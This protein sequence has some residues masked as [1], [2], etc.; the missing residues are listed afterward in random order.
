MS[1]YIRLI[2][3]LLWFF[4]FIIFNKLGIFTGDIDNLVDLLTDFQQYEIP[5][6]LILSTIRII[7][8]IPSTVFV[9]LGGI[10]LNP[11]AA[12]LLSIVSIILSE[13]IVYVLSRSL[14][15][16]RLQK[17]LS[18]KYPNIHELIQKNNSKVLLIGVLCPFAPTDAI[19]S[20][21]SSAGIKYTKFIAIVTAANLPMVSLYSFLG[22]SLISSSFNS[23]IIIVTLLLI[24]LFTLR[25]WRN[26]NIS[27]KR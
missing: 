20:L 10:I 8:F 16:V 14:F 25:L 7:S 1:K 5:V 21:S 24:S 22:D 18:G 13:S 11:F 4:I 6:F 17:Y 15:G 27:I 2:I 3:A 19:C 26:T 23:V 9:L 12:L